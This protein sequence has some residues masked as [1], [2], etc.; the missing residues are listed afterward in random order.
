MS[1]P[2][3][4]RRA[5]VT[6]LTLLACA[7]PAA[8]GRAEEELPRLG[9]D[10]VPTAQD[11]RLR[12][13]RRQDAYSGSVRVDLQVRKATSIVQFDARDMDLDHVR[14]QQGSRDI[15]V[16]T[17]VEGEIVTCT[18]AK[19]LAPGAYVLTLDFTQ[20]FNTRAIALY[21]MNAG[22]EPF[23]V[24][25][26]EPADAREAFP[27]WD[28]PA[29][30]IPFTFTIE[31]PAGDEV[32]FNTPIE[33]ES[34]RDGWRTVRF[35]RTKPL[36]TYLVAIAAGKLEYT[37]VPGTSVPTRI[38][39]FPGQ[40]RLAGIAAEVTPPVLAALEKW[41]GSPFP[42]EKNDF[43]AVPE[44][45]AGA[46]ENP[47]LITYRD[48]IL[49]LDPAT[50][51]PAQRRNLIR[52]VAHE[53][54]HMWYGDLVT[55]TWW[56]DLWLNESFADWMGD[57]ITDQ[58]HPELGLRLA[59]L[60]GISETMIEDS[61]PSTQAIRQEVGNPHMVFQNV[62][63]AYDKGKQ[64]LGM[65]EHWV[66]PQ[67]F[68]SGVRAYLK[69][70]AWGNATSADLWSSLGAASGENVPA[71]M[72]GFVEQPGVPLVR[73]ESVQGNTVTLAQ[74]RFHHT[75][76]TIP[77]QQWKIPVGLRYS[78]GTTVRTMSV[79]LD[80]ERKPVTLDGVTSVA[81]VMPNLDALGY[82]RWSVP[83]PMLLEISKRAPEILT[84][85]ER[86]EFL[87]NLRALLMAGRIHGDDYVRALEGFGRDPEPAVVS[88]LMGEL[89]NVRGTFVDDA[90]RTRFAAYVRRVL[91]PA[92]DRF[93]YTR[94]D[95][96]APGVGILRPQLLS[97]MGWRGEDAAARLVAAAAI[98]RVL[99]DTPMEDP[100]IAAVSLQIAAR[101]GDHSLFDTYV[102]KLETTKN[103]A[104]RSYLVSA[105]GRFEDAAIEKEALAYSLTDKLRPNEFF[106]VQ[107]GVS[108][109]S[110]AAHD[111]A[112]A[113][114]RE[115][116]PA[117][118]G[119]VPD[120]V[121][122][123]FA[124]ACG[125]CS[126][127]R[128]EAGRTFFLDPSR[129]IDGMERAMDEVGDQVHDCTGLRAREG[130]G[131]QAYFDGLTSSK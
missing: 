59:E 30:K 128:F 32:V 96:E 81:W 8:V 120:E 75:G 24:T 9:T 105:L 91:Q 19:P 40:G 63:L 98:K 124:R 76:V 104:V 15:P 80:A 49:L 33:K 26:F 85:A 39:S 74:E 95:G 69:A 62:G 27:C 48:N 67:E 12:L 58:L 70:H 23:L 109:R 53:L 84:P 11:V 102:A 119:R 66:G 100:S 25:Q 50:A 45:W 83:A 29:F 87:G 94:R 118:R 10:A 51:T 54:A 112:F 44:Y 31:V 41:F 113:W 110:D 92:V 14:L 17:A 129:T 123:Y 16:Q 122:P 52:I 4:V 114:M 72:A 65:F 36:P 47:G 88:A 99:T 71:V 7:T 21:K 131:V 34:T 82:Y 111:R 20:E 115:N 107:T 42:F 90:G 121:I 43:I 103:P 28:E 61:R 3:P 106:L 127:E 22:T 18:A 60:Q 97:W 13:D 116:W 2:H 125:G 130:A 89:D 56:D 93:G 86:V 101:T 6:A 1:A 73:V 37:H 78:D 35:K 57:K 117:I 64:V 126:S 68:Q 5:L 38:V 55:M 77:P 108:S 79:L 46:M